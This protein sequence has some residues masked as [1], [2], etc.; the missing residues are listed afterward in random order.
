MA[1][2]W[3]KPS[4]ATIWCPDADS[5]RRADHAG[6]PAQVTTL[7][8]R[9]SPPCRGSQIASSNPVLCLNVAL[10]LI[11]GAPIEEIGR[12]C[13]TENSRH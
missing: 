2:Y 5:T 6:A 3:R 1:P 8:R 13:C 9:C 10:T 4:M 11:A 7:D 12:S